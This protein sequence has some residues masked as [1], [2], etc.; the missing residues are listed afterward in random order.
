MWKPSYTV[1][2]LCTVRVYA[3][4]PGGRWWILGVV[5]DKS[6]IWNPCSCLLLLVTACRE[7]CAVHAA[8]KQLHVFLPPRVLLV[9]SCKAHYKG[10]PFGLGRVS[11]TAKITPPP[12][13][14]RWKPSYTLTLLCAEVDQD[15]RMQFRPYQRRI[16]S[17]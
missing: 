12:V 16:Y 4:L 2:L 8:R 7:D 10:T 9:R 14:K 5:G 6:K 1:T 3:W 17:A 15:R 11:P 13:T